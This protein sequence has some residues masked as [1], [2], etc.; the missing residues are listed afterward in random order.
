MLVT[1]C[2]S[3][4]NAQFDDLY[5]FEKGTNLIGINVGAKLVGDGR[6]AFSAFYEHGISKLFVDQCTLGGGIF[7]GYYGAKLNVEK[8]NV[9][10]AGVRLNIHYQFIDALDTYIGVAPNFNIQTNNMTKDKAI[11]SCYYHIGGRYY[12]NNWLGLFAEISTGFNN[13]SGGASVRF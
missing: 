13:F 11:F 7:G 1:A 10:I 5:T 8:L 9:Y 6:T 2:I 4:A 12:L 3:G